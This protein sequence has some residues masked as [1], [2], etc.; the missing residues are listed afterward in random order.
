[1]VVE[2]GY[3]RS[4]IAEITSRAGVSRKTFYRHFDGKLECLL[5]A[6]DAI[7]SEYIVAITSAYG[8]DGD[9][10]ERARAGLEALFES[11]AADPGALRLVTIEIAGTGEAGLARR[12]KLVTRFELFMR[13]SLALKP[14]ADTISTPILRAVVGGLS[15]VLRT[16]VRSGDQADVPQL[17][18]DLM[19]WASSY[20]DSAP[21]VTMTFGDPKRTSPNTSNDVW[22][23][24]APGTLWLQSLEESAGGFTTRGHGLSHSFLVHSQRERI[25]DAVANLTARH[26]YAALTVD[27]IAEEAGVS[28]GVL[29]EHFAGKEDAF[30]VAYELGHSKGLAIVE[31][32]F[33]AESDWRAGVHAGIS[34]LFDFLASE[35]SFARLALVDALIA[36]RRSARRSKRGIGAYAQ[37]LLPVLANMPHGSTPPAVLS[38]AI[39]GGIFELCLSYALMGR[40]GELSEVVP[41]ATYFAL[42]PFIGTEEAAAIATDAAL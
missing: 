34:A 41:C 5:E 1:V 36:T 14:R 8:A 26:G 17:V 32:A 15:R 24:R 29:N 6:Y 31:R 11:A 16:D 30:L 38:E 19:N 13:E 39:T 20:S 7:T 37:I 35:P 42:T 40:I 12:E 22:G 21:A 23:G 28:L 18:D 25:L 9:A 10:V 4:T 27:G 2:Q 33:F 3:A